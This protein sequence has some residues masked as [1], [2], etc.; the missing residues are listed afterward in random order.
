MSGGEAPDDG[1]LPPI[2]LYRAVLAKGGSATVS[3]GAGRCSGT[4]IGT[5][6]R[7]A[8]AASLSVADGAVNRAVTAGGGAAAANGAVTRAVA[9]VG[10]VAAANGGAGCCDDMG[11]AAAASGAVNRAARAGGGATAASGGAARCGDTDPGTVPRA[12]S[13]VSRRGADV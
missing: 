5:V 2:E 6:L 8:A 7:T 10:G 3:G 11:G 1:I 9:A 4:D 12:A 13:A